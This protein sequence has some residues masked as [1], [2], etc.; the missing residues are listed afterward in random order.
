M[1]L[2]KVMT[3][4]GCPDI[5]ISNQGMYA[6]D[7]IHAVTMHSTVHFFNVVTKQSTVHFF[8]IAN[9]VIMNTVPIIIISQS[10]NVH[11]THL[12]TNLFFH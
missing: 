2:Y 10:I 7:E 9:S 6:L 3:H 11:Y 5:I 4:Y 8:S 12:V 1:A